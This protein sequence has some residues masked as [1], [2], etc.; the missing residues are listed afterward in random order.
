M[1]L[2]TFWNRHRRALAHFY[3][4]PRTIVHDRTKTVVRRHVAPGE[5]VPVRPEAVAFAGHYN[6]ASSVIMCRPGGPSARS[7]GWT[8]P[9]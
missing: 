9:S 2:A 1:E 4:V 5:V 8:R 7:S 3:G 6:F